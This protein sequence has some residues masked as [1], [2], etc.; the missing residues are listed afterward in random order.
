MSSPATSADPN[1][2]LNLSPWQIFWRRLKRQRVAMFGGVVLIIL[3]VVAL[4]AGFIAPYGFERQDRDRFFHP[5]TT[6][7]FKGGWPAVHRYQLN[8]EMQFDYQPVGADTKPIRLLVRGEKYFLV[9][10]ISF[11]VK[12]ADGTNATQTS[13]VVLFGGISSTLHLF[14]TGDKEYPVYLLGADQFGRDIFSRVLYGSQISL[15]IGLIGIALSYTLGVL[16]G[17][18][19]GYYGGW[20]DTVIMR[21]CELIM[22]VPALYLIISLRA[23]FPPELSSRQMYAL[24]VVIFS[25]VAWASTARVVRGMALSLRERPYVLAARSLGQSDFRIIVRHI[26]PGTF[27]Y[28]IVAATLSVPYYILGEVVL[29]YLGVGIQE[30]DASWGLMLTAA[31]NVQHLRDFP[32]LLAPGGA[33][34]IAVLAFNFLGDGLRDAVDT[35]S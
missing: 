34:F 14:G 9:P 3:Y 15:S 29:S 11:T 13:R 28:L 8:P 35:K 12:K 17:G 24:I 20:V 32:W 10:E 31:Q 2:A 21:L 22:S 26:I 1:A 30:P 4:F 19:A 6:I 7:T 16:I 5:P 33:I 18:I 23:T 25:F 27:S